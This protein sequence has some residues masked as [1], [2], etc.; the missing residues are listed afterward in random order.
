MPICTGCHPPRWAPSWRTWCSRC[1]SDFP[2]LIRSHQ[3]TMYAGKPLYVDCDPINGQTYRKPNGVIATISEAPH[4]TAYRGQT[5]EE[6]LQELAVHESHA[7]FGW[8]VAEE[9]RNP[10]KFKHTYRA[11]T[12]LAAIGLLKK[13]RARQVRPFRSTSLC[14]LVTYVPDHWRFTRS[15]WVPFVMSEFDALMDEERMKRI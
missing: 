13:A 3:S 2:N 1:A 12:K 14:N 15:I 7:S 4:Y 5:I 10:V 6:Y 8:L 11:Y 9:R